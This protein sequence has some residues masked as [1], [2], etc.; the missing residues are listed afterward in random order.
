MLEELEEG[1]DSDIRQSLL[2]VQQEELLKKVLRQ[3]RETKVN[4]GTQSKRKQT[5]KNKW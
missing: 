3:N 4:E 2:S 5:K 1:M